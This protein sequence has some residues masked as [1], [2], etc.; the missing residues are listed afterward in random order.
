MSPSAVQGKRRLQALAT[1]L[2]RVGIHARETDDGLAVE[3]GP[4]KGAAIET[5]KD[6]AWP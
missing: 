2:C 4:A 5:Y 3:G 6:P 1:E